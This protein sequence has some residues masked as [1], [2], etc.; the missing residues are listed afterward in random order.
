VIASDQLTNFKKPLL[1][2]KLE[3]KNANGQERKETTLE[4]DS[5]ELKYFLKQLKAA[6]K[7]CPFLSIMLKLVFLIIS[8]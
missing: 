6:Q 7:V 8:K 1:L 4:L 5:K 2:L 3:T